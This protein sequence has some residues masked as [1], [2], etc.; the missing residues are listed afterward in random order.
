MACT[1]S[2]SACGLQHMAHK[3]GI[4]QRSL[5]STRH[6][7]GSSRYEGLTAS[8]NV[9]SCHCVATSVQFDT[10][11]NAKDCKIQHQRECKRLQADETMLAMPTECSQDSTANPAGKLSIK[12]G[13]H[14]IAEAA[15]DFATFQHLPELRLE[16]LDN[17]ER[18]QVQRNF[19]AGLRCQLDSPLEQ[20]FSVQA[21]AAQ[22]KPFGALEVFY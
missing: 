7:T 19:D 9:R 4:L 6:A 2:C 14:L 18:S 10:S 5:Y 17:L 8:C 16:A 11:M 13:A 12:L 1:A 22:Q 3:T 20:A 21:V 15:V